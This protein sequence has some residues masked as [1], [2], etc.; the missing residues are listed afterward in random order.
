MYVCMSMYACSNAVICSD[1]VIIEEEDQDDPATAVPCPPFLG[2]RYIFQ[3]IPL[4]W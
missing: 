1:E 4:G 3:A 2:G